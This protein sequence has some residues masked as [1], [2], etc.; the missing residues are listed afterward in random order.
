M[1]N[2]FGAPV[3]MPQGD[4]RLVLFILGIDGVLYS[5]EQ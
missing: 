5:I 3:V 2:L 4:G 1:P